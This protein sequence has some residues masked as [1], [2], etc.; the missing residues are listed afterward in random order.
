MV[1]VFLVQ[2]LLIQRAWRSKKGQA[3]SW[4]EDREAGEIRIAFRVLT[5]GVGLKEIGTI[6]IISE[7]KETGMS[8][9]KPERKEGWDIQ[10]VIS[11][12]GAIVL[13]ATMYCSPKLCQ[14]MV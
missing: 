9:N 11:L 3:H 12:S 8:M 4:E 13:I 6:L 7:E 14:I 5:E 2:T 10:K 1:S